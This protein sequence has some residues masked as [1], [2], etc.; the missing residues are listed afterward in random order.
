MKDKMEEKN[1]ETQENPNIMNQQ[2]TDQDILLELDTLIELCNG[3]GPSSNEEEIMSIILSKT[4]ELNIPSIFDKKGNL[5]FIKDIDKTDF[6]VLIAS[7]VDEIG[8]IVAE[9]IEPSY[10]KVEPLGSWSV[11][12]L[13][14]TKVLIKTQYGYIKGVFSSVPPHLSN[15]SI[16]KNISDLFVD[17]SDN[18]EYVQV[19]DYIVPD[20]QVEIMS[21]ST[22]VGK[23]FDNRIGTYVNYHVLK[24]VD[25]QVDVF[26]AFLVQ[27]E[28]GLRGSK[29]FAQNNSQFD[30]IIVIETTSAET[31]FS[32]QH[33][34]QLGKGP[35]ITIMDKTYITNPRLLQIVKEI[36]ALNNIPI[37]FKKPNVGSTDAGALQDIGNVIIISVPARYIHTP[38]QICSLTDIKNTI[39]LIS[40]LI[41]TPNIEE[42]Y[43]ER[44]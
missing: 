38:Y 5:T 3:F 13:P 32:K 37:Q 34:S 43:R 8:F 30:L 25:S 11:D 35:V 24:Y 31:P 44:L 14:S 36:A 10:L 19:G 18:F 20:S 40:A 7:H 16:G 26:H 29:F 15:V 23:A 28:L 2:T 21:N 27:E 6:R 41:A 4:Q 17:V 12:I 22:I 42:I 1:I 33:V 9:K 39:K